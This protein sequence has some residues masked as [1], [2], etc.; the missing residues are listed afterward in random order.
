MGRTS[1]G[2]CGGLDVTQELVIARDLVMQRVGVRDSFGHGGGRTR[3]LEGVHPGATV[4]GRLGHGRECARC[5]GHARKAEAFARRPGCNLPVA[6][7]G[8]KRGQIAA[9]AGLP[10]QVARYARRARD[11]AG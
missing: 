9:N 2:Q 4:G 5:G 1:G 11:R 10:D 3:V 7:M 8:A 6:T